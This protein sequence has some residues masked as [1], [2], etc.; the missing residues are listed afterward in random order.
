MGKANYRTGIIKPI[1]EQ[2]YTY[3]ESRIKRNAL[4]SVEKIWDDKNNQWRLE[5]EANGYPNTIK[6]YFKEMDTDVDRIH[7][8]LIKYIFPET[9]E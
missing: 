8:L 4:C 3:H 5:L 9:T 1:G 6:F 7:S 2:K